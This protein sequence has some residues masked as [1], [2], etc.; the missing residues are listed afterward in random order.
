MWTLYILISG[1][2]RETF[3]LSHLQQMKVKNSLFSLKLHMAKVKHST[4]VT[5]S[6]IQFLSGEGIN[7]LKLCYGFVSFLYAA[8]SACIIYINEKFHIFF[9]PSLLCYMNKPHGYSA[10]VQRVI[11]KWFFVSYQGETTRG[12]KTMMSE[13]LRQSFLHSA[14]SHFHAANHILSL[15]H[16][17]LFIQFCLKIAIISNLP[18]F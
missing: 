3:L 14:D 17:V 9:F 16:K 10:I 13:V 15:T 11:N 1:G 18:A 2:L 8:I 5:I 7:L 6:K 4:E 12:V